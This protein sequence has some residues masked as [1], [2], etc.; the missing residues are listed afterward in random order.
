MKGND[1]TNIHVKKSSPRPPLPSNDN[2]NTGST[3][4]KKGAFLTKAYLASGCKASATAF[5]H[6][7]SLGVSLKKKASLLRSSS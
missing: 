4:Y 2:M 5:V 6:S 7:S 3:G 1:G